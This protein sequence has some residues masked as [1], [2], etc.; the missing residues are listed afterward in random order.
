MNK[1]KDCVSVTQYRQ[2]SY[3][4]EESTALVACLLHFFRNLFPDFVF[5]QIVTIL[6][7]R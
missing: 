1:K 4:V 2:E 3:K 7:V 6:A 5:M